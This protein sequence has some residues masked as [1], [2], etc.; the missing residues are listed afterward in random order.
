MNLTTQAG[1]AYFG[2]SIAFP[3]PWEK[4]TFLRGWDGGMCG[5]LVLFLVQVILQWLALIAM[6]DYNWGRDHNEINAI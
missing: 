4:W 3:H 2:V 1:T 5:V 6:Y